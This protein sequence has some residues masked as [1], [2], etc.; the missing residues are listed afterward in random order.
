MT[1][2]VSSRE[3]IRTLEADGWVLDH[4]SGSHQIYRH[5][6]KSGAV[7]VPHPRRS[8]ARAVLDQAAL[9]T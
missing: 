2:I 5:G 7:V 9:L 1:K 3:L 8:L 4:V 6:S